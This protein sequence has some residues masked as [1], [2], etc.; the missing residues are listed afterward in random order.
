MVSFM[1]IVCGSHRGSAKYTLLVP[2]SQM[3]KIEVHR[4]LNFVEILGPTSGKALG[5]QT[6]TF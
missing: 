1:F 4:R 5:N 6:L 3:Q 2:F